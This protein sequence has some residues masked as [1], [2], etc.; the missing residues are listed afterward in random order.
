[1][2]HARERARS[3]RGEGNVIKITGHEITLNP[4]DNSNALHSAF[5]LIPSDDCLREVIEFHCQQF[6]LQY[7][8]C[9]VSDYQQLAAMHRGSEQQRIET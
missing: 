1:M 3:S 4:S 7:S 2:S 5:S 6:F 9:A 8:C